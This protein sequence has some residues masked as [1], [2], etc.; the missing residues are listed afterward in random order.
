MRGTPW[1]DLGMRTSKPEVISYDW[2]GPSATYTRICTLHRP[3]KA[4]S[5]PHFRRGYSEVNGTAPG[6]MDLQEP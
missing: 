1:T 4:A 5:R 6:N 3:S 2:A